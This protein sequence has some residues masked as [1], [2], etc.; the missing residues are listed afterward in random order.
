MADVLIIETLVA[1]TVH[2][3]VGGQE[4]HVGLVSYYTFYS[5]FTA[6]INKI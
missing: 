3:M 2:V 4:G 6:L 5:I 1:I